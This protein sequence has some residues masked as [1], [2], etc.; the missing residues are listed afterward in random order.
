MRSDGHRRPQR[1]G[2]NHP[3]AVLPL[4]LRRKI[5]SRAVG[6]AVVGERAAENSLKLGLGVAV[7]YRL[8]QFDL[9]DAGDTPVY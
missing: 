5:V 3:H 9:G 4:R 8:G 7:V 1:R 6:L 2:G